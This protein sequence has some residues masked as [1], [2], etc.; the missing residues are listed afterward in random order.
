MATG[1]APLDGTHRG[2][3]NPPCGDFAG[4]TRGASAAQCRARLDE[5]TAR[6]TLVFNFKRGQIRISFL[7]NV[8]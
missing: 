6:A 4:K 5:V 2:E 8:E 1:D 3:E 7:A